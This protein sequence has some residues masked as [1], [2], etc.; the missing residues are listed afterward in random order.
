MFLHTTNNF[1]APSVLGRTIITNNLSKKNVQVR[2]SHLYNRNL[3]SY[4]GLIVNYQS[5]KYANMAIKTIF[6]REEKLSVPRRKFILY[7]YKNFFLCVQKIQPF[8][9]DFKGQLNVYSHTYVLS[10]LCT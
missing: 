1:I 6:V 8:S 3:H 10:Y 5:L 2:L 7:A 9:F 4:E